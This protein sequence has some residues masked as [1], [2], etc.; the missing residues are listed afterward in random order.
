MCSEFLKHA[1]L[2]RFDE[3]DNELVFKAANCILSGLS[4]KYLSTLFD[5]LV[6]KESVGQLLLY[7]AAMIASRYQ[8]LQQIDKFYIDILWNDCPFNY[9]VKFA[10]DLG[11]RGDL[12]NNN[13]ADLMLAYKAY[14]EALDKLKILHTLYK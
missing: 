14:G 9:Q 11:F 2:N 10:V 5:H 12:K 6:Y 3:I 8:L 4:F 7:S 1:H 13:S